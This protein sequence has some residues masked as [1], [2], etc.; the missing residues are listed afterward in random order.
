MNLVLRV[1]FE[2]D[3][4]V[5]SGAGRPG[6]IDRMVLRDDEKLP[7]LPGKTLTGILRDACETLVLGLDDGKPGAWSKWLAVLFGDQ[8]ALAKEPRTE[9]PRPAALGIRAGRLS[10]GLRATLRD[11]P[12][13]RD[14]LTFVKPGVRLDPD[15]GAALQGHL[16]FI[17][18]VRGGLSLRAPVTI[19]LPEEAAR[20]TAVALLVGA[21]KLVE[22]LGGHRR[23]G[24]G[25]CEIL[26]EGPG[27]PSLEDAVK[28]LEGSAPH[29]PAA[30]DESARTAASEP[31]T[32]EWE[33]IDVEITTRSPVLI[34]ARVV[35]NVV[36]TRDYV[37]G[38]YLLRLFAGAARD[39][40]L[41]IQ[42]AIRRGEIL[43]THATPSVEGAAGR[44]VPFALFHRK[45]DGGLHLGRGVYN[46]LTEQAPTASGSQI[47]GHRKGYVGTANGALPG[48]VTV[49]K[50]V[51]T[52]NTV[53]DEPQRPTE[54]VGGV[55]TCEA[56]EPGTKL[57][58][59]IW[60]REGMVRTL[61]TKD[62]AWMNRLAGERSLGRSRKDDYG[63]VTVRVELSVKSPERETV[64][65]TSLTAWLVSDV[66]LRDERLRPVASLSALGAALGRELGGVTLQLREARGG[67]LTSAARVQRTESW[68][69]GWG[70]PRPTLTGL[71]G[72]T[73]AVFD[74]MEGSLTLDALAR[75]ERE[76]IGERRAEGYGR[77]LFDDP[78]LV[79][80]TSMLK[81]NVAAG[82][83]PPPDAAAQP[84]EEDNKVIERLER[85]AFR[86][87]IRRAALR[88]S[89]TMMGRVLGAKPP[90]NSQ[91]G[92]LRSTLRT[93]TDPADE[94]CG[95]WLAKVAQRGRGAN[96]WMPDARE[97][98][99]DLLM[100]P[101]C[102]WDILAI[103]DRGMAPERAAT[104]R[105]ELW[106]E[107][108]R[109]VVDAC[110]RAHRRQEEARQRPGGEA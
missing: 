99:T 108:V 13:L 68:H 7:Y 60:L 107:T 9:P 86:E 3:W 106:S 87:A 82:G 70:L 59:R 74:V 109:T 97:R 95:R 14:A 35:G 49:G 43:A 69:V 45:S 66:L 105:Q 29:A 94:D 55:Y 104:L 24:S 34:P 76:G 72:G 52:H 22:R 67:K 71:A 63:Q 16:R 91:L 53:D 58:G 61:T 25:R 2:S 1:T 11:R 77:V 51:Q 10:D 38:T 56:I 15:T 80:P 32:E 90:G 93:L 92:A 46:R 36:E 39:L 79:N 75:V 28:I 50:R 83:P 110:I 5:G 98:I 65:P 37:P 73:C 102:V 33:A 101:A 30:K 85:E 27:V 21:A 62:T 42:G 26:L 17:E 12:A 96:A 40:G 18:M 54:A 6:D 8:P 41:D 23:R 31:L 88:V 103:G 20:A 19:T 81:G 57:R 89:S 44:P 48:Y 100:N 78:L 64:P 4:H 84:D 47:K